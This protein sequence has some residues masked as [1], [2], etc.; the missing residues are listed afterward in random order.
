MIQK[1]GSSIAVTSSSITVL[2]P[3]SE[4]IVV[5]LCSLGISRSVYWTIYIPNMITSPI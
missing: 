1:D 3:E 5:H 4:N 2:Y